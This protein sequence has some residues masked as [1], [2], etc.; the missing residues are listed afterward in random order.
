MLTQTVDIALKNVL[1]CEL[2]SW[3]AGTQ[4]ILTVKT[5]RIG[6]RE[7]AFLLFDHTS[8]SK[9]E[10]SERVAG[11]HS[12]SLDSADGRLSEDSSFLYQVL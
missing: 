7:S 6:R 9:I 8:M 4:T 10:N 2:G 5:A 12:S 11:S 1:S 3:K